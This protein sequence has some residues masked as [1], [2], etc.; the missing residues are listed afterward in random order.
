M[1]S[2]IDPRLNLLGTNFCVNCLR[3]KVYNYA[4]TIAGGTALC[5]KCLKELIDNQDDLMLVPGDL[6]WIKL[7]DFRE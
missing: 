4:Q 7:E 2:E 5:L 6:S 3:D 1:K